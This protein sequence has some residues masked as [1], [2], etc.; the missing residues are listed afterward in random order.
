M[1][2]LFQLGS[3]L[4]TKTDQNHVFQASWGVLG[5]SWGGLG[6]LLDGRTT[7]EN[8]AARALD[9]QGWQENTQSFSCFRNKLS[10]TSSENMLNM[11]PK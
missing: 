9:P 11:Y 7:D 5:A 3:I 2:F 6:R 1:R 8:K 4:G 10:I